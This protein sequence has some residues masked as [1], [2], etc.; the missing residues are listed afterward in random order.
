[1]IAGS[2]AMA[3]RMKASASRPVLAA[4]PGRSDRAIAAAIGVDE[5]TV[6]RQRSTAEDSAVEQTIGLDGRAQARREDALGSD[7]GTDPLA[8][9]SYG[10]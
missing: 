3:T 5:G 10:G 6:R 7:G 9:V 8:A 1:M 4:N 2:T